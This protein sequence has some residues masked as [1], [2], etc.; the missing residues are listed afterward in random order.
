MRPAEPPSTASPSSVPWLD[1]TLGRPTAGV[2]LGTVYN[3]DPD[4]VHMLASAGRNQGFNVIIATGPGF[5]VPA[6]TRSMP[7]VWATDYIPLG[8][9]LPRLDVLVTAGGFNTVMA[10]LAHGIPLLSLP[11]GSDQPRN[12]RRA[13]ELGCGIQL[14][15]EGIT[16][17]QASHAMD[18]LLT[19]GSFRI[20][21]TRLQELIAGLPAP[22]ETADAISRLLDR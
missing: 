14:S 16:E 1:D 9:L 6:W 4:L 18:R 13:A 5:P 22:A 15:R 3:R 12:A 20:N 11:G 19:E 7:H 21:A 10:G 2:C 8:Q 17:A